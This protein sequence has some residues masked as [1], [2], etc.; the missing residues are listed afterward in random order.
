MLSHI[1]WEQNGLQLRNR[2]LGKPQGNCAK[3]RQLRKIYIK[4]LI[5]SL[6]ICDKDGQ[7]YLSL[8]VILK[9]T[10]Y[11]GS[12]SV[13]IIAIQEDRPCVKG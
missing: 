12:C 4:G 7:D 1:S 5:E 6:K 10:L 13:L 3:I 9:I 8:F 11:P 2:G